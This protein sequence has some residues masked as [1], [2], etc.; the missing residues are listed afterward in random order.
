[1]PISTSPISRLRPH[2]PC[3]RATAIAG[4]VATVTPLRAASRRL[5]VHPRAFACNRRSEIWALPSG[6]IPQYTETR[7]TTPWC[8][9]GGGYLP[10]AAGG[11]V[12]HWFEHG[13]L[14]G[15][16]EDTG[17]AGRGRTGVADALSVQPYRHGSPHPRHSVCRP[18][19][20]PCPVDT[21]PVLDCGVL[22]WA[23]GSRGIVGSERVGWIRTSADSPRWPMPRLATTECSC[24]PHRA[25]GSWPLSHTNAQAGRW[26]VAV[27]QPWLNT[28][29]AA[30]GRWRCVFAAGGGGGMQEHLQL[31]QAHPGPSHR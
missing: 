23:A 17:A 20:G 5:R 3:A 29:I 31:T 11:P 26:L 16:Q 21:A 4:Q 14:D 19:P 30:D 2:P 6:G 24:P 12:V 25:A 28:R 18:L 27:R 10:P 13:K 22:A 1:V 7:Y 8:A 15:R 9:Y